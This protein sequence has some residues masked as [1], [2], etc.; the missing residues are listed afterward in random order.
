MSNRLP[1]TARREAQAE[2]L[3]TAAD[4]FRPIPSREWVWCLANLLR[5]D[6]A[7]PE[8]VIGL[9]AAIRARPGATETELWADRDALAAYA[10]AYATGMAEQA[11]H[12][13]FAIREAVEASLADLKAA[14]LQLVGDRHVVA[15]R[16]IN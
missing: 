5:G 2:I 12:A 15:R 16:T 3:D 14:V 8:F 7:T 1:D 13:R 6:A 9:H 11:E 10:D 4:A